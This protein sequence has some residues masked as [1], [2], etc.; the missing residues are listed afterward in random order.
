V[1]HSQKKILAQLGPK[2]NGRRIFEM[3]EGFQIREAIER[4]NAFLTPKNAI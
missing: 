4:Y 1:K 3:E 2:I